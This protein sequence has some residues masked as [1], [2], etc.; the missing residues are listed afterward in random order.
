MPKFEGLLMG[1][2]KQAFFFL[3]QKVQVLGVYH[4]T[5]CNSPW[6]PNFER[7]TVI[8]FFKSMRIVLW[9]FGFTCRQL[10]SLISTLCHKFSACHLKG[11]VLYR[12]GEQK[13]EG[14]V[15]CHT[16]SLSFSVPWV[17]L[18]SRTED[19]LCLELPTSAA[20]SWRK[21]GNRL[22]CL[23]CNQINHAGFHE[24]LAQMTFYKNTLSV[25]VWP[26]I[27]ISWVSV[28]VVVFWSM[29]PG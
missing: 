17:K 16:K 13:H 23:S 14:M 10:F 9:V 19:T 3:S 18:C 11:K 20:A 25:L 27:H 24:T 26:Q 4:K 21:Q 6:L 2:R 29:V 8:F 22:T 5:F 1:Q 7:R 12:Q 28:D 15:E